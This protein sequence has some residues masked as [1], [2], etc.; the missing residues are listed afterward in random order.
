MSWQDQAA[1][2]GLPLD[3][4]AVPDGIYSGSGIRDVVDML[5]YG[6]KI[7]ATCP[8]QLACLQQ[9]D[10]EELMWTLRGGQMPGAIKQTLQRRCKGSLSPE[11]IESGAC[12]SGHDISAPEGLTAYMTCAACVDLKRRENQRL[13][14]K[15]K[16]ER[17]KAA[18]LAG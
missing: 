12:P 6:Q 3:W 9:A 4:F 13:R 18:K 5:N 11:Q 10:R 7:C 15:R 17:D 14:D 2:S 8:V 16:R 1:C